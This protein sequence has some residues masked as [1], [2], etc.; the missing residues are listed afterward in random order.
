MRLVIQE[1]HAK[2]ASSVMNLIQ[3]ERASSN[4]IIQF[5]TQSPLIAKLISLLTQVNARTAQPTVLNVLALIHVSNA[6][7]LKLF[8][9]AMANVA[10]K[11]DSIQILMIAAAPVTAIV[12]LV[13]PKASVRPAAFQLSLA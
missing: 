9:R 4:L 8:Y 13:I 5:Q 12:G 10:V 3:K 1:V 7:N 2:P 6:T 11:M